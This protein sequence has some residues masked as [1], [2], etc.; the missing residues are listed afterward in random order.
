VAHTVQRLKEAEKLG[1][2]AAL[3]P[4]GS[5]EL[6]KAGKGRWTEI[7]SLPD[8]VAHIAGSGNR[9]KQVEDDEY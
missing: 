6:P 7:E 3:L 1:F 5:A 8:L 9:F 2:S 4:S